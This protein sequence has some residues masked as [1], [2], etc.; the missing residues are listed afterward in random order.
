MST[1]QVKLAKATEDDFKVM[2]KVFYA[3][4]EIECSG[5]I[6]ELREERLNK[7]VIGR[8]LKRHIKNRF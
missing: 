5:H 6:S 8:L 4:Q 2:W 1:H 7:V 3:F